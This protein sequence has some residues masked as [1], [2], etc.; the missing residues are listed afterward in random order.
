MTTKFKVQIPDGVELTIEGKKVIA[1]G[2]RGEL[3]HEIKEEFVSLER[4]DNLLVLSCQ[5]DIDKQKAIAGTHA[6][7]IRNMLKGVK[8]GYRAEL[9]LVY[10]HFP[11]TMKIDGNK[12]IVEN[13]IGERAQRIIEFPAD[14]VKVTISG[15]KISVE[16]I[17][18][19]IVGQVAALFEQSVKPKAKDRRVFKDGLYITKKP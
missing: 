14:K 3:T 6:A 2:P 9:I 15:N 8:E 17:D 4:K 11:P 5:R 7:I 1:K 18:K 10:Q 19:Y 16:G 13:F 12:L